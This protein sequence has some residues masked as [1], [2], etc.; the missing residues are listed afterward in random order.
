MKGNSNARAKELEL[1]KLIFC[2]HITLPHKKSV[3][4]DFTL[5]LLL[6]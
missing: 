5:Y 4:K 6:T 1:N 3:T 2:G